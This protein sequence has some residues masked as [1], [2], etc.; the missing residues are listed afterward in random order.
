LTVVV[1]TESIQLQLR[2][3]RHSALIVV[4]LAATVA[5]PSPVFAA[6]AST[7]PWSSSPIDALA[8]VVARIVADLDPRVNEAITR[9]DGDG[10][11]LLALRSYLRNSNRL[12]ER[13]SWTADQVAAYQ[14]TPEHAELQSEI[15]RVRAAFAQENPGFELWVNPQVRNL[16]IQLQNWNTNESVAAAAEALLTA[17]RAF[18]ESPAF[19]HANT[20]AGQRALEQFLASHV[21]V[22]TPTIA[23]PGLSP[24]GQLRA[25]DFQVHKDGAI[26]AGT[27]TA[28]IAQEWDGA[29]WTQK[30]EA[31]VRAGSSRFVGPLE[32]P[33]EPWHY[34]YAPDSVAAQ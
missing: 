30:L 2:A 15:E 27:R 29:G 17:A 12:A 5:W 20:A 6:E 9:M 31:A 8:P 1:R 33:R 26:V 28:T 21:P 22:P 23:A 34:T 7:S 3:L 16:D 10:R 13:W 18:A 4:V 11:R 19:Q 32:S 25:I 14:S 24:H